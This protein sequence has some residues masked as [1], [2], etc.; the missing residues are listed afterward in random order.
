MR[1]FALAAFAAFLLPITSASATTITYTASPTGG[2]TYNLEF[3][4][5]ND[6]LGAPI[7]EFTIFF[8]FNEF[9]NLANAGAPTDWDP[10]L[11]QPDTGIPD[12]G[13]ADW[14]ALGT[15]LGVGETLGGFSLSVGLIAT[16]LPEMLAFTIIDPFTFDILDEGFATLAMTMPPS[17]IPLPAAMWMFLAGL[18]VLAHKQF[19]S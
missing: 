12:D 14:L 18:G 1:K 8:G 9:E 16:T 10:L 11:I 15:P 7:E 6:T 19:R 4:V 5:T 13:F 2:S 17:E 3:E